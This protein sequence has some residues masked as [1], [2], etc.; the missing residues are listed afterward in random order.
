MC[1][2]LADQ[3]ILKMLFWCW[4]A[5]LTATACK[6]H[7]LLPHLTWAGG[8]D[9]RTW[10]EV[11]PCPA[12]AAE[13]ARE[14][15]MGIPHGSNAENPAL[16]LG[17]KILLDFLKGSWQTGRFIR[18]EVELSFLHF[19]HILCLFPPSTSYSQDLLLLHVNGTYSFF[20]LFTLSSAFFGI[21]FIIQ[22][23]D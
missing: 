12:T 18:L 6:C 21:I 10:P 15:P 2:P 16:N 3:G 17:T 7:L 22:T 19:P 9:D 11:V 14:A 8:P 1:P 23:D 13:P 20:L 5:P 4:C